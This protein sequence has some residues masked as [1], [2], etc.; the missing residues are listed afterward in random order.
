MSDRHSIDVLHHQVRLISGGRP[1]VDEPGDSG[2][3]QI[4]EHLPLLAEALHGV[5]SP[6]SGVDQFDGDLLLECLVCALRQ[7]DGAHP[8][9]REP[10]N[11]RV[12]TE[13]RT[14]RCAV[15][16]LREHL[17]G[18][19]ELERISKKCRSTAIVRTKERLHFGAKGR[20]G[21]AGTF[22]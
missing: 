10:P 16:K 13:A 12:R 2:M 21:G 3:I 18:R 20:I 1:A 14:R 9:R 4:G 11:D 7:V 5:Q 22:E 19:C 8:A 17:S 6:K 15:E